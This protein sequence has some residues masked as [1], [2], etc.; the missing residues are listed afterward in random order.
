MK[1]IHYTGSTYLL[2]GRTLSVVYRTGGQN[3]ILLDNGYGSEREELEAV[4][5]GNGLRPVGLICSHMHI[6]HHGNSKYL[7]QKYGAPLAMADGE[8]GICT[9][10]TAL[11]RYFDYTACAPSF[12]EAVD[13]ALYCPVDIRIRPEQ[14]Q[15]ELGGAV[16]EVLHLPGHSYDDIAVVTPDGVVC[17]GDVMLS[18]DVISRAKMPLVH[19][20]RNA[21]ASLSAVRDLPYSRWVMAHKGTVEG[22]SLTALRLAAAFR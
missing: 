9:N 14:R 2:E 10:R 3:C 20:Y 15:L 8:A 1:L 6:D 21:A 13:E 22:R 12:R 5:T 11:H 18:D 16:F 17:A 4:L 7:R 19:D